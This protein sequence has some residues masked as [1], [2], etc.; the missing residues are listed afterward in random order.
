MASVGPILD[1]IAVSGAVVGASCVE[2]ERCVNMDL[3]HL[4]T[5]SI[6]ACCLASFVLTPWGY[7][8]G[9]RPCTHICS[10]ARIPVSSS[11]PSLC[12]KRQRENRE[13]ERDLKIG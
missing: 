1:T 5:V 10:L 3:L 6:T 13:R 7:K 9:Y 12:L 11:P 4:F 2:L 8:A